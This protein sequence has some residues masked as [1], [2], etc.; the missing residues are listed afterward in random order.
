MT[1]LFIYIGLMAASGWL[2]RKGGQGYPWNTKMRDIGVPLVA[3]V[4]L[5]QMGYIHWTMLLT[6]IMSFATMT[7]YW[8]P[9]RQADVLWWNWALTGFFYGVAFLPVAIAYH[10]VAGWA[11]MTVFLAVATAGWSCWIDL[12][13]LEEMGRGWIVILA[14]R[15]FLG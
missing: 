8:T 15:V 2:Y 13:W 14:L 6:G 11:G 10:K 7:T 9:K 5:L 3:L 4:A 12:D 1:D